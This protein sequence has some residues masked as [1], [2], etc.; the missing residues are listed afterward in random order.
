MHDVGKLQIDDK[1]LNKPG[2]L[3]DDEMEIVKK[4]PIYSHEIVKEHNLP[5]CVLMA[6]R[7]HHER[8]DGSGYPDGLA[9]KKIHPCARIVAVA[10]VY[11][12]CTTNKPYKK[13]KDHIQALEDMA[14]M[15]DKFD[16]KAFDALLKVVFQNS[17]LIEAFRKKTLVAQC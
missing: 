1:I 14:E 10:D 8:F 6:A 15:T 5:E 4:H 12:A 2:R 13:A 7:S 3:T 16:P 11:D 17:E 9:G